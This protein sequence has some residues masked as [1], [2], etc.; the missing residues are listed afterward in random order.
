MI[1]FRLLSFVVIAGLIG[2]ILFDVRRGR[3]SWSGV[4]EFIRNQTGTA[5][6]LWR[7]RKRLGPG[8]SLDN[9]RRMAY[10]L[11][12]C[13]LLLLA[14]TG[15]F[16]VVV[17]G[18]HISG[19]LLIIHVTAAP[20]FALCLSAVSLLWAHRSRFDDD[21]WHIVIDRVHRRRMTRARRIRLALKV[22]FWLA[23]F[24]S[25]PLMGSI[26]LG[27]F[28]IFGTEGEATLTRLHGYS[29]LL[30]LVVSVLEIHLTIAYLES[31][32]D[33]PSKESRQ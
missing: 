7:E 12:A 23:L 22:G 21:D 26:I 15:F 33:K 29:A 24:F 20:L 25:L 4:W 30:L 13:F 18:E 28:P 3:R 31:T 6:R 8:S 9:F 14:L 16:P 1:L 27:L 5:L 19:P 32:S 2:A 11:S 10:G 17:L